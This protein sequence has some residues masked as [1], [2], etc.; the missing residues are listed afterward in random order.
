MSFDLS[1]KKFNPLDDYFGVIMQQGRVQL[2]ADWNTMVSQFSRRMQAESLDTFGPAVVP[3]ETPEGF[4]LTGPVTS[5]KI[6]PGRIYVD[7]LLAENHTDKLKWDARLAEVSGTAKLSGAD[8]DAAPSGFKGTTKYK[9]Q[10][11]YPNPPDLPGGEN[12]LVYVDVWQRDISYLQDAT[13]VDAAVGVDTTARQQTVW[14][15]KYLEDVGNID[16]STADAD[17]PG[18]LETIHPSSARLSTDTGTLTDDDNPCLLPPQAGYKGLENQLYRV[19]VHKGGTVGKAS[20]K[21]SRDNAVVATRVSAILSG[22]EIVVDSLGRDDVLGF[23]EGDWVEITDDHRELMGLPGEIRRIQ[24]GAGINSATRTITLQG[25][26]LPIGSGSGQFPVDGSHLTKPDRNTRLIRWDQSGIVFR[27]NESEY[28]DLDASTSKGVIKIPSGSTRLFLEKGILVDF[29]LEDVVDE[30]NFKPEFKTGDYWVFAARVN[31]ASVEILD[32]AAPHGTHHH[33]AK[34]AIIDNGNIIDCR[35]LWPPESGGESCACT[36]CV[37]PETHNNG[38]ATIQQAIDQ[39]V[40]AGGGTVCLGVGRYQVRDSL[41]ISGN[42]VTL[43]GQGWQTML[44]AS[45]PGSLITIGGKGVVT[46]IAVESLLGI[47]SAVNGSVPAIMVKNVLGL[48]INHCLMAN[49]AGSR[50]W[51]DSLRRGTSQAIKLSGVAAMVRIEDCKLF[52]EHGIVGPNQ[53]E[54]FLGTYDFSVNRCLLSCPQLGISFSGLSYHLNKLDITENYITGASSAGIELTGVTARDAAVA[55]KDNLLSKCRYGIRAAISNLRILSN[56]IDGEM[57]DDT[58]KEFGSAIVFVDGIDPAKL[59]QQ[60]TIGNRISNYHGHAI[61]IETGIGNMMVKQ[62]QIRNITGAGFVIGPGGSIEFLSLENNQ[63]TDIDGLL[64]AEKGQ[65]AA[66]FL[67]AC[68]RADIANNLLNRVV[69]NPETAKSRAGIQITSSARTSITGNHL[70]AVTPANFAGLGAGIAILSEVGSFEVN[71]NEISRVPEHE[72]KETEQVIDA[73]WI[74]LFVKGA[75][76]EARKKESETVTPVTDPSRVR[77]PRP[78]S[79]ADEVREVESN[80]FSALKK[81]AASAPVYGAKKRAYAMAATHIVDLGRA[82]LSKNDISINDNKIDGTSSNTMSVFVTVARY[83][84]LINNE[85]VSFD[86]GPLARVTADHV[87]VNNN[88]LM[89]NAD[90]ILLVQSYSYVVMGNMHTSGN[91]KVFKDGSAVPLP[92]PWNAL[93]VLI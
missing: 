7:G 42:S 12:Y 78:G 44:L 13:L 93:N 39:V 77:R 6:G 35:T 65:H 11:Y 83:C 90:N 61:N 37:H 87:A 40:A 50:K 79:T 60:Q 74:P 85:I 8:I 69:R 46:D 47:T 66:I 54:E 57:T 23:H 38:S 55:V 81:A 73:I 18:W 2:D 53:D 32:H 29:D 14:Q 51:G 86:R 84:G 21:W 43:R 4:L 36:V 70:L 62:N 92:A 34:L 3:R 52:A 91:I 49:F 64:P 24:L 67:Q 63:F 75:N 89:A 17:I 30:A 27:E 26:A 72:G 68:V 16:I 1:R 19:Q 20:F 5:F 25:A 41:R 48:R 56:D 59:D 10:P 88:R 9:D 15:V 33:Y 45:K 31:D 80:E 82:A 22:N 71:N 58:D 28:T 76:P